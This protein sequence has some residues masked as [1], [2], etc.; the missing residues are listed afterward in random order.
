MISTE[1]DTGA[2]TIDGYDAGAN[3][4]QGFVNGIE[5]KIAEVEAAA[6]K[7]AEAAKGAVETELGIESPSK[8]TRGSGEF[9]GDGLIIGIDKKIPEGKKIAAKITTLYTI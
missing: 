4:G 3:F 5:D 9:F 7:L 6:K 8:V 2:K 1:A